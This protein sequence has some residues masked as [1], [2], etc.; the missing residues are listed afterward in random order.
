MVLSTRPMTMTWLNVSALG[1]SSTG[2]MRT[3]GVT[4]AATACRYC[5]RPISNPSGVTAALLLMFCALN[6]ATRRPQLAK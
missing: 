5:A 2:F 3:C 6:G 1:F 4:R